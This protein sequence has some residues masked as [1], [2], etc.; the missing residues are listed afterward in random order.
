MQVVEFNV[1]GSRG[2]DQEWARDR[3]FLS[4]SHT[5]LAPLQ[6]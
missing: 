3:K 6:E 2:E 5:T 4:L 1:G